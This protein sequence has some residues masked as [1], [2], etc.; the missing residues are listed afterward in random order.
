MTISKYACCWSAAFIHELNL[1]VYGWAGLQ[2]TLCTG[3][4]LWNL[5]VSVRRTA[6][7]KLFREFSLL[8]Q[9]LVFEFSFNCWKFNLHTFLIIML[10]VPCSRM[11]QNVPC[12][13]FYWRLPSLSN[14]CS[15][16]EGPNIS[17]IMKLKCILTGS[18]QSSGLILWH[19][20]FPPKN[21]YSEHQDSPSL[22]NS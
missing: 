8:F 14:N 3:C 22:T 9:L 21:I 15:F 11:F 6:Q 5:W 13:R 17:E 16:Q 2:M 1:R 7:V 4:C 20:N 12:S 10:I 19:L 18:L